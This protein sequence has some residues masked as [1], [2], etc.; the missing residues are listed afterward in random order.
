MLLG[1]HP[2][3][4]EEDPSNEYCLDGLS[5][6][7]EPPVSHLYRHSNGPANTQDLQAVPHMSA[8]ESGIINMPSDEMA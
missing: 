2:C 6:D 7:D 4:K 5:D 8:E 1:H 3:V